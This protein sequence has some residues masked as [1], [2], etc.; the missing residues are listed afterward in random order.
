MNPE[1]WTRLS[2]LFGELVEIPPAERQIRLADPGLAAELGL[3][4]LRELERMLAA[5]TGGRPLALEE[6]VA[7]DAP[8]APERIGPYRLERL[9]GEGGMGEVWL[10]ERDEPGSAARSR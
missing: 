2:E 4:L 3:E 10:A 5:H 7:E 8:T 6:R 1:Q 9:L